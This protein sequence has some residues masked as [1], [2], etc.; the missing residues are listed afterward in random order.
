MFSHPIEL[1][2]ILLILTGVALVTSGPVI[3]YRTLRG[4]IQIR[5]ADPAAS[6]HWVSNGFNF[7]IA[8]VFFLAGILFVYNNLQGNPLAP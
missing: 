2:N 5:R 4:M 7:L 6:V 3:V 1:P 8:V